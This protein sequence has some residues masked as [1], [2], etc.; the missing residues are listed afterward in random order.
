[1]LSNIWNTVYPILVAILFFELIIII[2]EGGHFAAA[3][4]MGIKVNEFSIGMGP[5]VFQFKKGETT[6]SLRWILFGGYC[7]MEGEDEDSEDK[8]AFSNKKVI[9]RIFVVVAGALMNLVL[10]FIIVGIIVCSQNLVGTTTI[11]KFDDTA[12]SSE[13]RIISL[14]WLLSETA[15]K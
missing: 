8:R 4:L 10:G 15:R 7:A 11:A 5:K 6:Y 14:I 12:I 1:M 13:A 2:H 3:R 9:Q